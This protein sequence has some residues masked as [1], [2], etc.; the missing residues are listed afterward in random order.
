M[1]CPASRDLTLTLTMLALAAC[2]ETTFPTG[3]ETAGTAAPAEPSSGQPQLLIS[4]LGSW[5]TR[6]PMPTARDHLAA[7][8]VNN[9]SG[10]PVLYAIGGYD[11]ILNTALRRVEAYN[12]ATN[13]WSQKAGL[14]SGRAQSNGANVI[15]GKIYLAGGNSSTGPTRSLYV[16]DPGTNSWTTKASMPVTNSSGVSGVINGKLYVLVGLCGNCSAPYP[17]R[18]YRYD[19][20]SNTWTRRADCPRQHVYGA[21]GVFD[22]KLYVA[23]GDDGTFDIQSTQGWLDVYNP[24]TNTWTAKA[25]LPAPRAGGAATVL[26][27]KL[28]VVGGS[29]GEDDLASV[30]AYDPATN[31][32]AGK[33]PMGTARLGLVARTVTYGGVS[34]ILA[35]GGSL[36]NGAGVT[37]KLERYTP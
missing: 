6:A 34:Y 1:A 13:T 24:V 11:G 27:K 5:T 36:S 7:T 9:S 19:P 20:S 23:G 25:P 15:G 10:Q 17:R 12:F 28:Y 32:W 31:T 8:V 4:G 2:G 21:A 35:V 37:G 14:P 30:D 16:Y 3:P 26:A 22:G 29:E 33:A 18:L